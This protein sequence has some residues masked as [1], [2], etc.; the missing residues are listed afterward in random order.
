MNWMRWT[1]GRDGG[2]VGRGRALALFAVFAALSASST[3][4]GAQSPGEARDALLR[5]S[6]RYAGIETVC[7]GFRQLLQIPLLGDEQESAGR[8]CQRRP[9]L[10]AMRFTEPAGDAVVADGS[11]F[12]IYY[13]SVSPG[14]VLRLPVDPTRGGLDFYREFL[15]EPLSK[16]AVADG[17]VEDVGGV[18]TRLVRLTP[19]GNRGYRS[20]QVWIDPVQGL[21]RK[22]EVVEENGT[23]RR[24]TLSDIQVDPGVPASTFQFAVP[25]GV[26]VVS[27]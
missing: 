20:A 22:V 12:W 26:S 24:I 1:P 14:Q 19:L 7:A 8:V 10:F 16:Y 23:L 13:P 25:D 5:A 9:N 2:L 17:G 3:G 11:H 21:I 27:R 15:D 4:L 6:E 18:A